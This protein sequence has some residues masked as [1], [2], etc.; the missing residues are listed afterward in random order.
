M[1]NLRAIILVHQ[2]CRSQVVTPFLFSATDQRVQTSV[3]SIAID[4]N[5]TET[6]KFK[7]ISSQIFSATETHKVK[8]IS[9]QIFSATDTHKVRLISSQILSATETHKVRLISSQIFSATETHK[10]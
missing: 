10:V 4:Q 2:I 7:L 9:S 1:S 8:L 5:F 6:R 3:T